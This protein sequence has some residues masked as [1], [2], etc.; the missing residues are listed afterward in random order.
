MKNHLKSKINQNYDSIEFKTKDG[1]KIDIKESLI[2][3]LDK[4]MLCNNC[5]ILMTNPYL[6]DCEHY[7]CEECKKNLSYCPIDQDKI[8]FFVILRSFKKKIESLEVKCP[9]NLNDYL[10]VWKGNLSELDNHLEKCEYKKLIYS[11][12]DQLNCNKINFSNKK[13]EYLIKKDFFNNNLYLLNHFEKKS[14][15]KRLRL[16]SIFST[17]SFEN[18]HLKNEYKNL[19][20]MEN[21]NLNFTNF[22]PYFENRSNSIKNISSHFPHNNFNNTKFNDLNFSNRSKSICIPMLNTFNIF[23]MLNNSNTLDSEINILNDQAAPI[24]KNSINSNISEVL[25]EKDLR[26][27][28]NLENFISL[29]V[30]ENSYIFED[31]FITE[32]ENESKNNSKNNIKNKKLKRIKTNKNIINKIKNL[33]EENKKIKLNF[34]NYFFQTSQKFENYIGQM[35]EKFEIDIINLE[36]K[37][38]KQIENLK[39]ENNENKIKNKITNK[40]MNKL[41]RDFKAVISLTKK[42]EKNVKKKTEKIKI[43]DNKITY[44]T[45]NNANNFDININKYLCCNINNLQKEKILLNLFME[46]K[47]N[48]LRSINLKYNSKRCDIYGKIFDKENLGELE[49]GFKLNKNIEILVFNNN[50]LGGNEEALKDILSSILYCENL[51]EISF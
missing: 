26:E 44:N 14:F 50:N 46:N 31:N 8:T 41:K 33:K 24:K 3:E 25:K 27:N 28:E 5:K 17:N 12:F 11:Y 20:N 7:F 2:D 43:I 10:C 29:K 48:F 51:K 47:F 21:M 34:E 40:K 15:K 6:A 13:E 39:K 18:F 37:Y 32:N 4:K 36:N 30:K 9:I 38:E 16:N 35:K 22:S 1:E 42:K 49:I 45:Y 23:N 19:E